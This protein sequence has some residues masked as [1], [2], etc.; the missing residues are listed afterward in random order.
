M[1]VDNIDADIPTV[2]SSVDLKEDDPQLM[3]SITYNDIQDPTEFIGQAIG[4]ADK[5]GNV[6]RAEV[7][8]W[9][10]TQKKFKLDFADGTNRTIEYNVLRD[11]FNKAAD[12]DDADQY[13]TFSALLDHRKRGRLWEVLLSSG[14]DMVINLPG[15]HWRI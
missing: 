15:N 8:A 3:D 9:D 10:D 11:Q 6:Q 13:Y 2:Y 7:K 4:F 12:A 14:M 5:D 1:W